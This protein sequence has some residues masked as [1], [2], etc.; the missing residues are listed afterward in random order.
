V[1][2]FSWHAEIISAAWLFEASILFFLYQRVKDEKIYGAGIVLFFIGIFSLFRLIPL[3]ETWDY[4]SLISLSLIFG[5]FVANI[6]F[7]ENLDN[8]TKTPH[9]ILHVLWII[10]IWSILIKIIPNLW[11]WWDMLAIS[12]FILI[13]W[14]IYFYFKAE[15]L[16]KV[17]YLA[18]IIFL[19]IHILNVS[20][21]LQ[22][23]DGLPFI[24]YA[25]S[26]MLLGVPVLINKLNKDK[27]KWSKWVW[28]MIAVA[29]GIYSLIMS[30]IYVYDFFQDTFV[31]TMYWAILTTI[32]LFYGISSDKV[33]FRTIGLYILVLTVGKILLIDIWYGLDEPILRVIALMA[34]GILM[35]VIS[36]AYNKK[37]DGKMK[38]EFNLENFLSENDGS[39]K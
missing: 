4:L 19:V 3:T 22:T 18:F 11:Q 24:Q 20:Y 32:I 6:K 31:I 25:S 7:L 10:A 37:Y 39:W 26:L 21:I 17:F 16:R 23:T 1:F 9:D 35:I 27:N 36:G 2:L 5:S 12:L 33:R 29:F 14:I 28:N 13:L 38:E 15:S 8:K 34:V 30:T